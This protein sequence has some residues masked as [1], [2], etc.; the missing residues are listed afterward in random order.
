MGGFWNGTKGGTLF[1]NWQPLQ[2]HFR[3]RALET[4]KLKLLGDKV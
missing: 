4:T 1:T 2:H 3:L